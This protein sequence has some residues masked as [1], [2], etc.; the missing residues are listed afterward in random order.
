MTDNQ[1]S[2]LFFFVLISLSVM[3]LI[4]MHYGRSYKKDNTKTHKR[5]EKP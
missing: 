5:T 4:G 1:W 2:E 3:L